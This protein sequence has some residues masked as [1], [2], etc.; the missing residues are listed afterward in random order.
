MNILLISRRKP[1]F[2]DAEY[3][4]FQA[5]ERQKVL[6]LIAADVVREVRSFADLTGAMF[7]LEADS[8]TAALARMEELPLR[9]A[10]MLDF[11]VHALAP[12]RGF[13]ALA[14]EGKS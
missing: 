11:E 6:E 2:S 5:R 12:Y 7:I 13:A 4:P 10:G 9:R 3:A 1:Q 14:A 8:E